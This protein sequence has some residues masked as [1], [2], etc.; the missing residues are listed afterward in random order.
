V[1]ADLV[2]AI[3]EGITNAAGTPVP[4]S[5]PTPAA[6]TDQDAVIGQNFLAT[7]TT[8]QTVHPYAGEDVSRLLTAGKS[9]VAETLAVS[10]DD[11]RTSQRKVSRE[12]AAHNDP[13]NETIGAV[14]SVVGNGRTIVR[15]AGS[16]NGSRPATASPARTTPVRDAVKN[17]STEI[18]KIVTKVSDGVKQPLSGGN[19]DDE[20]GD[21]GEG[22]AP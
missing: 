10:Q 17:A 18:T 3:G 13:I 22:A 8:L 6:T 4:L 11:P 16:D 7:G 14:K 19:D 1:T 20:T 2:N 5:T 12:P 9:Q 21:G 15:S